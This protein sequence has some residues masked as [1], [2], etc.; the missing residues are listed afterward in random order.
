V[1]PGSSGCA[2]SV[3]RAALRPDD[4]D[5]KLALSGCLAFKWTGDPY[6][7]LAHEFGHM[8]GN[9]DGYFEYGSAK[10]RDQKAAQLLASGRPEDAIR[11][12]QVQQAK[13]SGN[14]SHTE[15]QEAFGELAESAGEKIPEFGP[16]TSSIMSAGADVLPLLRTSPGSPW[17]DHRRRDQTG[18]VEDHVASTRR[19]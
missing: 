3:A 5:G 9:P 17:R 16:K 13:P 12:V 8:L 14:E 15:A 4:R 19:R 6:S 1:R 10:V 7:I 2:G 18:G 11:A